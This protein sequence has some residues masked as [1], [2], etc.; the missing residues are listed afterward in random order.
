MKIINNLSNFVFVIIFFV[1]MINAYAVKWVKG[2]SNDLK[3]PLDD[4]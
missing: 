3:W 4:L 2:P 1:S